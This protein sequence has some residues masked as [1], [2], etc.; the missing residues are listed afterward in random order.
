LVYRRFVCADLYDL[1]EGV[2]D[3]MI[4]SLAKSTRSICANIFTQFLLEYPLEADRVE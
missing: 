4:T 3:L 1:L 2:Q